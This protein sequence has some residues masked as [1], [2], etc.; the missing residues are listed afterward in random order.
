[1][2]T[3]VDAAGVPRLGRGVRMRYDKARDRHVLLLPETVVVLN[4]TGTAILELCDGT[5]TVAEIVAA[6]RERYGEVPEEQVH[7]YLAKLVERRH[8]EMTHDH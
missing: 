6:L 5:R 4:D 8:V 1:V 2:T 3:T 7:A